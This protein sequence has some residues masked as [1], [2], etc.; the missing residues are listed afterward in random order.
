MTIY[1]YI[2]Q[3]SITGLKYFGKT[4]LKDPFKYNGSGKVWKRHILK[5]GKQNIKTLDVWGFDD[6]E[7]CINF[8]IKFS[9]KNNI[10]NSDKWANLIEE[11]GINGGSN[12]GRVGTKGW[13]MSEESRQILS[14][15]AKKRIGDKN[16][17]YRKTHTAYSKNKMS[18]SRQGI[19]LTQEN[20]DSISKSLVAIKKNMKNIFICPH[21]GKNGKGGT[22]M[23]WHFDNCKLSTKP[24]L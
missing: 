3:H 11:N 2:K 15:N 7:L 4:T 20:K 13:K 1:L 5:H 12:K 6:I 19:K 9:R 16:P 8:A 14:S 10:V 17:F 23:R 18:T 21:C 24:L 22:M